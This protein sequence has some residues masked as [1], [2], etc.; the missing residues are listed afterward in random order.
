M[1]ENARMQS[2]Q[3][4][5]ILFYIVFSRHSSFVSMLVKEMI[6]NIKEIYKTYTTML[7]AL[8]VLVQ[9]LDRN[10]ICHN[11]IVVLFFFFLSIDCR[12]RHWIL[13]SQQSHEGRMLKDKY[14]S[15]KI[16]LVPGGTA[17]LS[18]NMQTPFLGQSVVFAPLNPHVAVPIMLAISNEH[19]FEE[20]IGNQTT[21]AIDNV[22]D[23]IKN[24]IVLA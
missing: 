24:T 2:L 8:D 6:Q 13:N 11:H 10:I 18:R 16:E 15:R 1:S 3:M 19:F 5:N 21:Q 22:F 17:C 4:N 9:T 23:K 20:I 7:L 14:L 12:M